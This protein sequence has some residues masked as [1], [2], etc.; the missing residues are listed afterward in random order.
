[1]LLSTEGNDML[2]ITIKVEFHPE[3]GA[4]RSFEVWNYYASGSKRR[5]ASFKTEEA[6]NK[7]AAKSRKI[8][9]IEE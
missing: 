2:P 9:K 6:A 7:S 8:C 4:K 3:T 1:M 5:V